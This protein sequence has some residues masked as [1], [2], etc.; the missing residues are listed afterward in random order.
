VFAVTVP[1]LNAPPGH[2]PLWLSP[3]VYCQY[4]ISIS[5]SGDHEILYILLYTLWWNKVVY[6][7]HCDVFPTLYRTTALTT[8]DIAEFFWYHWYIYHRWMMML[9]CNARYGRC[10]WYWCQRPTPSH[11]VAATRD[12]CTHYSSLQ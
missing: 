4:C 12:D 11:S 7:L 9:M 2:F 10:M 6:I 3:T 5:Y 8:A 1:Q